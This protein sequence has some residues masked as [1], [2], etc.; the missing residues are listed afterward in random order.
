MHKNLEQKH[1]LFSLLPWKPTIF[2][3][4]VDIVCFESENVR[5]VPFV[6]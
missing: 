2:N 6:P 4:I 1:I 3:K 5:N